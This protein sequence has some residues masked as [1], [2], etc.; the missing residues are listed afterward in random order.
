MIIY[1]EASDVGK[2]L[3]AF[4][5]DEKRIN[6][7]CLSDSEFNLHGLNEKADI[8]VNSDATDWTGHDGCITINTWNYPNTYFDDFRVFNGKINVSDGLRSL[9]EGY[10]LA[11]RAIDDMLYSVI[12]GVIS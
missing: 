2:S 9:V 11:T 4:L 7:I 12:G 1:F 6:T 8:I 5:R 3:V 10:I